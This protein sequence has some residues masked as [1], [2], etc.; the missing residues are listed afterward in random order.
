MNSTMSGNWRVA[1][2]GE[3]RGRAVVVRS[4]V[5]LARVTP[6]SVLVATQTDVNYAAQMLTAAAVLTEDG[7]RYSHAAI[8]CRE[9]AIPCMVGIE[10]LL[11]AVTDGA[12]IVVSTGN[13][14]LE[15][16]EVQA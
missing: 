6:G 10:G 16:R 7:G 8:F 9:N 11:D 1:S 15:I 2:P 5:D 12:E 3:V 13:R 14:T 4:Q